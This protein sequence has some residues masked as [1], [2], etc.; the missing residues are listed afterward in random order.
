MEELPSTA[1]NSIIHNIMSI[2]HIILE[3]QFI[4]FIHSALSGNIVCRP[5]LLQNYDVK[6]LLLQKIIDICSGKN[7]SFC[8]WYTNITCLM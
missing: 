1:N 3:K 4:K 5:T 2:I 6:N 7:I 8:N